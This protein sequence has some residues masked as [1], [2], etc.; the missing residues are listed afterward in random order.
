MAIQRIFN[1]HSIYEKIRSRCLRNEK[2]YL[3]FCIIT[4]LLL[5]GLNS[6]YYVFKEAMGFSRGTFFFDVN[7]RFADIIK[8][9]LS[10]KYILL[11]CQDL[12]EN[13]GRLSQI[14]QSYFYNNPYTNNINSGTITHFHITPLSTLLNIAVAVAVGNG[15]S[16]RIILSMLFIFCMSIA[17]ISTYTIVKSVKKSMVLTTLILISYPLLF[18]ITRGN[19]FGLIC[20]TGIIS[21][22]NA[23]FINRKID[24][25]TVLLVGVAINIRPNAA[26][27]LV[28]LPLL[29]GIKKS[30][31]PAVKILL[32]SATLFF[33]SYVIVNMVYPSY[34]IHNF[35]SA[36]SVYSR[37][38][39]DSGWG[40]R[41]NSSLFSVVKEIG[42]MVKLGDGTIKVI[43]SGI[44]L[45]AI[46]WLFKL[47]FQK[48]VICEYF[49]FI[50]S[51]VYVMFTP[52]LGD[53][54]LLVFVVPIFL[55]YL[56]W[57]SWKSYQKELLIVT[58]STILILV[59]K[60]YLYWHSHGGVS[61]QVFINPT[62]LFCTT[63]YLLYKN[64][65]IK[66]ATYFQNN[67]MPG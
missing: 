32:L 67:K 27:L 20:G 58:I 22:L 19:Y 40:D 11:K 45:A 4:I 25:F 6:F 66:T 17:F 16:P 14:Y 57:Q 52:V 46:S 26:V 18:T 55:I 36:L 21:F 10:Y 9:A 41:F 54:H 56:G 39:V 51:S 59:P 65:K 5:L 50:L 38:Y 24:L 49:P 8:M 12:T 30:I 7:D 28:G 34:T 53:Y 64:E 43:F 48:R 3:A 2:E 63:I 44:S 29:L 13:I 1:T 61:F 60:N 35:L 15:N 62:I 23:L 37:M 31:L 42:H 47:V 33:V